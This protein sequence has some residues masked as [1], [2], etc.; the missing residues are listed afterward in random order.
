MRKILVAGGAGFIGANICKT[1]INNGFIVTAFD[2]YMFDPSRIFLALRNSSSLQDFRADARS[3]R[4]VNRIIT[5]YGP[6][7]TVINCVGPARPSFYINNP[8]YTA[9]TLIEST[10]TLLRICAEY[11][12]FYIHSSSSEVYGDLNNIIA[13]EDN[14]GSVKVDGARSP[15]SEAKRVCETLC[16]S[17]S[18]QKKVRITIF[19]LFNVYGPGTGNDDDRVISEFIKRALSREPLLIYGSGEQIRSFTYSED[20]SYGYLLATNKKKRGLVINIGTPHPISI[21]DIADK[22]IFYTRSSSIIKH[23]TERFDEV[24]FRCPDIHRAKK[25]LNWTPNI[26]IDIGLQKTIFSAQNTFINY[27]RGNCLNKIKYH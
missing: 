14:T 26:P 10:K 1:L 9:E 20:V 15:Y 22:I 2:N 17:Y 8:I 4:S 23:V 13:K 11:N 12:S 27:E 21:N 18:V 5:K 24:S 25:E 6:F 3:Y 7:D 16:H 19:R